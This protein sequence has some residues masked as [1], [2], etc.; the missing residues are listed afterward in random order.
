MGVVVAGD[1]TGGGRYSDVGDILCRG[2][3]CGT[4][5]RDG[6]VGYVPAH[7]EDSE[8]ITPL[9][10]LQTEKTADEGESGWY[11]RIT[12]TGGGRGNG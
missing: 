8:Q 12:P 5:L 6:D 1:E 10:A 4:Y 3:S 2:G 11:M 9:G 7:W